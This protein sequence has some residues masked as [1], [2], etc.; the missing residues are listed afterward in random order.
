MKIRLFKGYHGCA[1]R[2]L[3][4]QA[5]EKDELLVICPPYL[6]DMEFIRLLPAGAIECFGDWGVEKPSRDPRE[7]A[8]DYPSPPVLGVFTS[9]TVSG[10]PRLVLYSKKNVESSL[11]SILS[12][13]DRSRITALFCYPQPFHTFGLTLGYLL[14]KLHGYRL[15]TGE[16]KYSASFHEAR[17]AIRDDG[18]LTL[19]TPTHFHDLIQHVRERGLELAPSYSSITGG[20]R[21]SVAL[22]RAIRDELHVEAPSIGY[23]A[24]EAAPG[25]AHHPPGLE[26]LEDG[27]IGYA[28]GQ[29]AVRLHSGRGVEFWGPSMCMA[30]I[31]AGKLVFPSSILISDD[32]RRRED[33]MLV[34]HGRTELILNRGG[35]KFS[36]ERMEELVHQ[37]LGGEVV[38]LSVP[39]DRLGEDL[40]VL[41]RAPRD[42][43][44]L[45]RERVHAWLCSEFEAKFDIAKFVE[46]PELPVNDN[47]KLDRRHGLELVL[48]GSK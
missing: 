25:I 11:E 19:G 4:E 27:E 24:T 6:R 10:A 38:C 31:E 14:A 44:L 48:R 16:G 13:F 29:L 47:A 15:V 1:L 41:V 5:W 32:V 35:R 45:L 8:P 42:S 30:M 40:G 20:A 7:R 2:G 3:I 22:W 46:V 43:S 34:Y 12:V 33:G 36:L 18:L 21:V 28:L 17:V 26:P 37:R 23:G 9:G 39:D